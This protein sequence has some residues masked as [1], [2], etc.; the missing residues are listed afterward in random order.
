MWGMDQ[1]RDYD[2]K[3]P[4][5]P[6]RVPSLLQ[7]AVW[8]LLLLVGGMLALNLLTVIFPTIL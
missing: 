5:S 7:V 1:R 3:S 2:D 6:N 8:I 4:A